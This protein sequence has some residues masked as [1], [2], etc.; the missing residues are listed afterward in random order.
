MSSDNLFKIFLYV[1]T[2][3]YWFRTQSSGQGQRP[4]PEVL[5]L[6]QLTRKCPSTS[7][8]VHA[9]E[10]CRCKIQYFLHRLV[11][12]KLSL[13]LSNRIKFIQGT[14][15]IILQK[16][17]NATC[18][19]LCEFCWLGSRGQ[20]PNSWTCQ[21]RPI[22]LKKILLCARFLDIIFLQTTFCQIHN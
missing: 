11:I 8:F 17:I 5:R 21:P 22:P 2:T 3:L 15:S 13:F 6:E 14:N 1:I 10:R 18:P 20:F 7:D 16:K 19:K 4:W 12:F 9:D